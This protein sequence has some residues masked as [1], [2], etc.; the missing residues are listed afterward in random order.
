MSENETNPYEEAVSIGAMTREVADTQWAK[1]RE[2]RP[3]DPA[4]VA[5]NQA[6]EG[7]EGDGGGE[8]QTP[9]AADSVVV[10]PFYKGLGYDS[11]DLVIADLNEG[12]T[13]RERI[14]NMQAKEAEL[15]EKEGF[16]SKFESP[17]S[18]DISAKVDKAIEKTGIS[19]LNVIG[20]LVSATSE[21]VAGDP[22]TA[23]VIAKILDSPSILGDGVTFDDLI[24][25]ER[26]KLEKSGLDLDDKDSIEY[27]S[28]V[29]DSKSALTKINN[30]QQDL[31]NV[32]GKYNFAKENSQKAADKFNQDVA[33]VTPKVE[34]LLKSDKRSFEVEGVK[35]DIS[36]SKED[37]EKIRENASRHAAQLGL[38]LNT[39]EGVKTLNDLVGAYAKGA[40]VSSGEF[41]KAL[42]KAV[43]AKVRAE[44]LDDLSQGKPDKRSTPSGAGTSKGKDE[45]QLYY[46]SL[47]KKSEGKI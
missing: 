7:G 39:A 18:H 28:L 10:E 34:E 27:K 40:M 25:I 26:H 44:V 21:S 37:R 42:F 5:E 16:I 45:S 24:A 31:A 47:L 41:E 9:P 11:E 19:D 35:F 8:P 29:V 36:L 43:D 33:F 20:K 13:L 4:P 15:A 46:E 38:N 2:E 32:Q 30:F 14:A 6:F 1:D 23:I 3:V 12:K 17:Y 22:V